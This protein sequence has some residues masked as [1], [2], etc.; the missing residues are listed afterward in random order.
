MLQSLI[1]GASLR[2]VVVVLADLIRIT[3]RPLTAL[4]ENLTGMPV[5][6]NADDPVSR[7]V[8]LT[9]HEDGRLV[10]AGLNRVAARTGR[11]VIGST[12]AARTELA[13][14]EQ[15]IP[16]DACREL[17]EGAEPAGKILVR[18]GMH[19]EDRRALAAWPLEGETA[20]RSSAVLMIGD[21][22]VAIAYEEITAEFCSL[23]ASPARARLSPRGP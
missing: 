9:R 10:S 21:E 19:R 5:A 14:L 15:R 11:T 7:P 6:I 3:P 13:W 8:D 16:W 22:P 20:I 1:E 18:W 4:L 2:E 17:K 12:I 23:L